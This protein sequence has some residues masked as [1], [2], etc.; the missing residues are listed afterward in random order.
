MVTIAIPKT[1]NLLA[2]VYATRNY[3]PLLVIGLEIF[4]KAVGTIVYYICA[5]L[6][7]SIREAKQEY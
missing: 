1:Y 5:C 2:A 7:R 3:A 6:D 4:G